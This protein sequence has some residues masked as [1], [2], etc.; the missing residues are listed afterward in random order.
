[1][2]ASYMSLDKKRI[3]LKTFII[4]QLNYCPLVWMCHSRGL[5]NRIYNLHER[6]PSI[7][8]QDKKSDF[9]TLVKNC[10]SAGI[11]EKNLHILSLKLTNFKITFHQILIETFFTFKKMKTTI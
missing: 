1:M 11:H 8:Y 6:V 7:V 3:L 5:N 10:K 4:L 9:E 2:V